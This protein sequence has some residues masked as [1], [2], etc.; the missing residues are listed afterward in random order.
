MRVRPERRNETR[1]ALLDLL[2]RQPAWFLHEVDEAEIARSEHDGLLARD[3]LLRFGL[4]LLAGRLAERGPDHRLLFVAAGDLLNGS[5]AL[6][7]SLHQ[8]VEPIAVPL[9]ERRALG[10]AVVRE[11]DYRLRA[12]CVAPSA[13]DASEL[14]VQLAQCFERVRAFEARVVRD[15]VVAR[16]GGVDGRTAA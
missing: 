9:L 4:R 2:E 15:L 8:V 1:V 3:V 7:R 16:E 5:A 12:G 10:L 6:E 11:D 14:L 13:F